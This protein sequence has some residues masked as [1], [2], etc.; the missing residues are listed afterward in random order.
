MR[1]ATD[2][3]EVTTAAGG[4]SALRRAP[5]PALVVTALFLAHAL[6]SW[7]WMQ[8]DA[9]ITFRYARNLAGGQGLVFNPGE[10][11]EGYTNFLWVLF[12][13]ASESL[14]IPSARTMPFVGLACGAATVLLLFFF[15]RRLA[16]ASGPPRRW[17]GAPAALLLAL[18]PGF[19]LYAVTG[20]ET[21]L[22]TALVLA[23]AVAAAL[24]RPLA[25]AAACSLAFL[26]RPEAAL[27]GIGGAALLAYGSW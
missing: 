20:L 18:S 12:A 14:G 26:V 3:C 24:G 22:F 7:G 16:S 15:G 25:F 27:L 21:P 17:A 11:V 10:R 6:C 9:Y 8:D 13:A 4:E 23:S 1:L 5:L 19:A 2:G